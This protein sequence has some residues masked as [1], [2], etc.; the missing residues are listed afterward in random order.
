MMIYMPVL[1]ST[2]ALIYGGVVDFKR[3]EI[4]DAVPIILTAIG[5][6]FGFSLLTS[7]MGLV[8]PAMLLFAAAQLTKSNIPGGDFKLLCALGFSC[9][10]MELALIIFLAGISAV[11]YGLVRHLPVKR[12]IPLC[13]Y[14][15][16]AYIAFQMIV[17]VIERR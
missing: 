8:V 9:G 2:A 6:L 12:H 4:P 11:V 1:I 3:R 5:V 16:S 7:I 17:L 14:I 13:S 15:A 10:L